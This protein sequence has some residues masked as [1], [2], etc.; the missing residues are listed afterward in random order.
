MPKVTLKLTEA[1]FNPGVLMAPTNPVYRG[2]AQAAG[3]CVDRAKLNLTNSR[4]VDT[5]RLRASI[6]YEIQVHGETISAHVGTDVDYAKFI[7]DGT[8]NN[9]TGW[10]YPRRALVLRFKPKGSSAVLFRGRV[11]GIK[12]TPFLSDAIAA[13]KPADFV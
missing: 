13:S 12:G 6:R 10:I 7:H 4:R 2:M 1:R 3:R 11:R 5:G 8:A 9:G